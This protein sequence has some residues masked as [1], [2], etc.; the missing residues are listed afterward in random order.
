MLEFYQHLWLRQHFS[1]SISHFGKD[2]ASKNFIQSVDK[3]F[4]VYVEYRK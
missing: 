4:R 2:Y 1:Q 3:Y